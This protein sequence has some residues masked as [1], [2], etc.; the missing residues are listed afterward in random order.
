MEKR[1]IQST[2]MFTFLQFSHITITIHHRFT[3]CL[4]NVIRYIGVYLHTPSPD[5]VLIQT[6]HK[7]D[8]RSCFDASETADSAL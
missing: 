8:I 1:L 4:S 2:S 7:S 6:D 5:Y 3:N